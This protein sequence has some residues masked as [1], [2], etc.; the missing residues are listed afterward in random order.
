MKKKLVI[1]TI[2]A[3]TA[4]AGLGWWLG[5][6]SG[7]LDGPDLKGFHTEVLEKHVPEDASVV[8]TFDAGWVLRQ[9]VVENWGMF[10]ASDSADDLM[11]ALAGASKSH[12]GVDITE[13]ER[14]FLWVSASGKAG[15]LVIE[16]VKGDLKGEGSDYNGTDV[17]EM[18]EGMFGAVSD[19][20]LLLGTRKGV[21][22]QLKL[23]AGDSKP[24]GDNKDAMAVHEESLDAIDDGSFIASGALGELAEMLPRGYRGVRGGAIALAPA[25]TVSA[26]VVG[27][28][29]ALQKL[30]DEMADA[31]SKVEDMIDEALDDADSEG[32]GAMVMG[33]TVAKHKI[34]D[35]YEASKPSLEGDVLI[36]KTEGTRG[37]LAAYLGISAAVAGQYFFRYQRKAR[38]IEAE[39]NLD[40]YYKGAA[41]HY[42]EPEADDE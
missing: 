36:F 4:A 42:A 30:L 15:C 32:P 16:G 31:R 39:Q 7:S 38:S 41:K 20:R 26:A 18:K 25:G 10:P 29:K 8:V 2:I 24:L 9:S 6:R 35:A 12:W 28:K 14:A 40:S 13:M 11:K 33:L 37:L 27:K 1:A 23:M 34:G 5:Q 19:G 21:K 22:G 3:A 17:V